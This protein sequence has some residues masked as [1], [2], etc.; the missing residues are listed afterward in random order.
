M[1]RRLELFVVRHEDAFLA[2]FWVLFFLLVLSGHSCG[3][4]GPYSPDTWD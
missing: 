1:I 3:G 4:R 2:A